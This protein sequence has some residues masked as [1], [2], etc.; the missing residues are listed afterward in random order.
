MLYVFHAIRATLIASNIST[1]NK[2]IPPVLLRMKNSTVKF[3][4][5]FLE[6]ITWLRLP[7]PINY[8]NVLFKCV[9]MNLATARHIIWMGADFVKSFKILQRETAY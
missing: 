8:I 3:D 1:K 5:K 2:I 9:H 6:C 4:K 7:A